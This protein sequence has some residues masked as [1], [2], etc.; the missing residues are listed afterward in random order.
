M[1]CFWW[2]FMLFLVVLALE[3]CHFVLRITTAATFVHRLSRIQTPNCFRRP[4]ASLR[5]C[6]RT[7]SDANN[8]NW[9]PGF[10]FCFFFFLQILFYF[11]K[12]QTFCVYSMTQNVTHAGSQTVKV[13]PR[14][15]ANQ[16]KALKCWIW[17]CVL[18]RS[19]NFV[20][21]QST[22]ESIDNLSSQVYRSSYLRC[23][24]TL[25]SC[26]FPALIPFALLRSAFCWG[27]WRPASWHPWQ[28]GRLCV[29]VSTSFIPPRI[30]P[31]PIDSAPQARFQHLAISRQYLHHI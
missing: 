6:F 3:K 29:C 14:V 21:N 18:M 25:G 15:C 11:K 8:F 23:F 17:N 4:T 28:M 19:P 22:L 7:E 12:V 26:L 24:F 16:L 2:L 10:C 27:R 1:I 20:I 9:L 5:H 30:Q 13:L 31:R